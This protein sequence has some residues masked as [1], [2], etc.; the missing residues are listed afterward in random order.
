MVLFLHLFSFENHHVHVLI[1]WAYCK[2][3][4]ARMLTSGTD[5]VNTDG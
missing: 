4:L 1:T 3:V 2:T 5:K